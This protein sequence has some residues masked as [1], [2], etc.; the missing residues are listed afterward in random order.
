[1]KTVEIKQQNVKQA[2]TLNVY[3]KMPLPLVKKLCILA[4]LSENNVI[5]SWPGKIQAGQMKNGHVRKVSKAFGTI[6]NLRL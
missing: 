4:D 5:K 2:N 3:A 6:N 1:M